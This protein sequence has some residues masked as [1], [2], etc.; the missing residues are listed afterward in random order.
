MCMD[1]C[2][3]M[4]IAMCMRIR[5]HMTRRCFGARRMPRKVAKKIGSNWDRAFVRHVARTVG[6]L[7]AEAGHFE[8]RHVYTRAVDTPSAMADVLPI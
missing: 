4:R 1:M 6:K 7:S 8:Y 5:R 2:T 3:D